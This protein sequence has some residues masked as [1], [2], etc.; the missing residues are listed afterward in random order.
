MTFVLIY[1]FPPENRQ[2]CQAR[3]KETEGNKPPAGI[4]V[5]GQWHAISDGKG[6]LVYESDDAMVMARWAQKWSDVMSFDIYPALDG[7]GIAKLLA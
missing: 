6:V 2:A 5:L 4:K 1:S 3:F 7:E